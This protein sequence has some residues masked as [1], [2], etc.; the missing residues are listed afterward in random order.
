VQTLR[1]VIHRH[2]LPDIGNRF[3]PG[4]VQPVTGPFSFQAAE[5]PLYRGIVPAVTYMDA[6]D[7]PVNQSGG[8]LR[9]DFKGD[10]DSADFHFFAP[11]TSWRF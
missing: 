6:G 4:S 11:H 9:G 10:L 7:A 8:P 2:I 1:V 3:L 5:E